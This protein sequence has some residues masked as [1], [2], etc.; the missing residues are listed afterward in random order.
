MRADLFQWSFLFS[1][2]Q[3]AAVIGVLTFMLHN[4]I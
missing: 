4:R 2:G 3:L 1:I